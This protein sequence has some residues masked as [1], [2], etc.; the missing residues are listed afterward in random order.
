MDFLITLYQEVFFKPLFNAL[1]FLTSVIPFHDL[2]FAIVILTLIVRFIIFPFTHR[3]IT[4]QIKMKEIEPHIRAIRE[5]YKNNQ[6][7]IAKKTMELYKQHGL[8]PFSGCVMVIIQFPVLIALYQVFINEI[9]QP[10]Q[11]L[12]SFIQF[13]DAINTIFLG[14]ISLSGPSIVMA[15]L[16]GISQFI[17][18]RLAIP[19]VQEEK[20]KEQ[21]KQMPDFSSS[22]TKQAQYIFP[23]FV[24]FIS[25]RF[26]AALG[27]YWT[28]SN[29]FAIIHEGIV[30]K[31]AKHLYVGSGEKNQNSE[32][33]AISH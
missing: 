10:P 30:R 14:I 5:K 32:Y 3:S 21:R 19:R 33:R 25:F 29:I 22:L 26:P 8:S 7:E 2:G 18:M 11:F 31:K 12:Y 1:I 9:S 13:P 16:A 4:T 15:V 6:Q 20:T 17:Q 23:F 28:T 24:F 27:L